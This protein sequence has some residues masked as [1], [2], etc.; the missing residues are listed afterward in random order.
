MYVLNHF[1]Q[2]H[3]GGEH[4]FCGVFSSMDA[5]RARMDALTAEE[6][7]DERGFLVHETSMDASSEHATELLEPIREERRN[8]DRDTSRA[9]AREAEM[10]R[11]RSQ[12]A[13]ARRRGLV[14]LIPDGVLTV[15]KTTLTLAEAEAVV[16]LSEDLGALGSDNDPF[17][18]NKRPA[19]LRRVRRS[20]L[21]ASRC[22]QADVVTRGGHE[23]QCIDVGGGL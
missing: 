22:L 10:D 3:E 15:E 8:R 7:L 4:K 5:A 13:D 23:G 21:A 17:L 2:T 9:R 14:E 20:L 11:Q 1:I 18:A 16:A 19:I 12:D 6:G